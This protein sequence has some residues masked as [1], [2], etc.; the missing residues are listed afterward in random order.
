MASVLLNG[1]R[2][3]SCTRDKDG[4][5]EY[6]VTFL[7]RCLPTDGPATALRAPGLPRRGSIWNIDSDLDPWAWCRW[8]ADV[9]PLIDKEKNTF[10]EITYTFS[11]KPLDTKACKEQQPDNPLLLPQEVSFE[12][13]KSSREAAYDRFGLPVLSSSWELLRGKAVEFD[14]TS[15]IVFVKQNVARLGLS[16]LIPMLNTLND[17]PLWDLPARKI[18]FAAFNAQPKFHGNCYRYYERSLRFECDNE[19]FDRD[20]MDEGTKALNGK[21]NSTTGAWQLLPI[22][23]SPPNFLNP[24]HF[25]RFKDRKGENCRVILDGAG[26]PAGVNVTVGTGSGTGAIGA[27]GNIHVE[28]YGES[29]LLLLGIPAS[30]DF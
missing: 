2:T 19:G 18:R 3:W 8:D 23:D 12:T 7:V 27:P 29:N 22:N 20:V 16:T 24:Q 21:W 9:K 6:K 26:L 30:I 15:V 25:C 14:H 28:K 4:H 11:S 5:R 13:E 1:Q 10:F 17:R